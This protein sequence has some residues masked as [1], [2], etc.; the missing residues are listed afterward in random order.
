MRGRSINRFLSGRAI[1]G[2]IGG[3]GASYS[4]PNLVTIGGES[5]LVGFADNSDA[6]LWELGSR[7]ELSLWDNVGLASFITPNI[8][9]NS[10]LGCNL[11]VTE[12]L[13]HGIE[14]ALANFI[15][16]GLWPR[17]DSSNPLHIIK[18]GW[19]GA[20]IADWV[21][22]GTR[23][24]SL[25]SKYN[26]AVA[27]MGGSGN[28]RPLYMWGLGIN[29][30]GNNT[31]VPTFKAAVAQHFVDVRA[32]MGANTVICILQLPYPGDNRYAA[33]DTANL[34][35]AQADRTGRT[36][37]VSSSNC[38]ILNT[39]THD[40]KADLLHYNYYGHKR[41]GRLLAHQA[42]SNTMSAPLAQLYTLATARPALRSVGSWTPLNA[43]SIT[44]KLVAD[45]NVGAHVGDVGYTTGVYAAPALSA[46]AT[47]GIR[48]S[49]NYADLNDIVQQTDTAR[50][51]LRLD[52]TANRYYLKFDGTDDSMAWTQT[53]AT[54]F[55]FACNLRLSGNGDGS[56]FA[57]I[58]RGADDF[59]TRIA[60]NGTSDS[61]FA[62]IRSSTAAAGGLDTGVTTNS[63]VTNWT[64]CVFTFDTTSGTTR[65]KTGFG[66]VFTSSSAAG[67]GSNTGFLLNDGFAACDMADP[68]IG[69]GKVTTTE[70]TN[71]LLWLAARN[72]GTADGTPA[73]PTFELTVTGAT[74]INWVNSPDTSIAGGLFE[75]ASDVNFT[76]P[77]TIVSWSLGDSPV[78]NGDITG[79]T[80]STTYYF[81][82][83]YTG[84]IYRA[85]SATTD[86]AFHNAL[87]FNDA[88]NSMYIGA[89]I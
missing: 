22:G 19:G 32:L 60:R 31:D 66:E 75:Y 72:D 47:Y 76:S 78:S 20:K 62:S 42:V 6:A 16:D 86:A 71:L 17:C 85:D 59:Q 61:R 57:N 53:I 65:L 40:V 11:G 84:G 12:A 36:V 7:P 79:L 21:L 77:V 51:T 58:F 3:A 2:R 27:A 45:Y 87:K 56:A 55:T 1:K 63:M 46:G 28:V 44:P 88:R 8:G 33:W 52:G 69:S 41:N 83:R 30:S 82:V 24:N 5:T 29:D 89:I 68:V 70:E 13:V 4:P 80:D 10:C 67:A 50:P 38:D 81:R 48:I 73:P 23:M 25:T 39:D 35:I 14:L 15:R 74:S 37:Y 49:T 9:V 64:P 43:T 54:P 34:Q 26:N 18:S